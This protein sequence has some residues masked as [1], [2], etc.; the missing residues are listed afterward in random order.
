[1]GRRVAPIRGA[2]RTFLLIAHIAP[3]MAMGSSIQI[4]TGKISS[5]RESGVQA[6]SEVR[7]IRATRGSAQKAAMAKPHTQI[8]TVRQKPL[9]QPST[10]SDAKMITNVVRTWESAVRAR[11]RAAHLAY[12]RSSRTALISRPRY[13][14]DSENDHEYANSPASVDAMLPP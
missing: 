2:A 12:L 1:M 13:T 11:A 3:G 7:P 14:R 8:A 9:C 6:M 5:Q 4:S 10:N